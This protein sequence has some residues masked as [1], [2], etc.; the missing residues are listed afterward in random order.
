MKWPHPCLSF[1]A[2]VAEEQVGFKGDFIE[3]FN[4]LILVQYEGELACQ[5]WELSLNGCKE[6]SVA[7]SI[8]Q[9]LDA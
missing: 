4:R 7:G 1:D 6:L 5:L 3:K 9:E 2:R 8:P